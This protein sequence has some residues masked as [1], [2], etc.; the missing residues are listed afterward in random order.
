[1]KEKSTLHG[2]FAFAVIVHLII[3]CAFTILLLN[4]AMTNY[5]GGVAI[6]KLHSLEQNRTDVNLHIDVLSAQTGVSRFTELY[7]YWK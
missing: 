5:P 3:N 7:P 6:F 1:M 2:I 4:V